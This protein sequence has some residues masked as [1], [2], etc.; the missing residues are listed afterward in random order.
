VELNPWWLLVGI[1]LYEVAQAVRTRGW[2]NILRASYPDSD[3]L[4]ARDVTAAYLAGAG[5]NG[6]VP[7]RGGDFLKVFLVHRRIPKARYSTL[8][9]TFGPETI[10]EIVMSMGLVI[11]AL[12]HGFLPV[13]VSTSDL[14][15]FDVSF[16]MTHP[17]LTVG[18]VTGAAA[19]LFVLARWCRPR[20]RCR[21]LY[22]RVKQGF[23]I[24]HSPRR[25]IVG[26]G[27]PQF[28]SRVVRLAA[29]VCL[30]KAVGLPVTVN[31]AILVMAAMSAG[32]I[33]PFA[34]ASTGLRVAML[35]YGFPALTDKPID[36]ASITSFWFTAGAVHLVGG[37]LISIGVLAYTFGTVSPRKA[38]S[39]IKAARV[40][41]AAAADRPLSASA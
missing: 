11:W 36:I 13:P 35:A 8:F 5:I 23:E 38:L 28:A 25:F 33:I 18:A 12:T 17:W 1:V 7:A 4:R 32:R 24:M 40:Q 29:M 16:V 3:D 14:P 9:A 6:I 37:L 39:A 15:E 31:T 41:T 19:I 20:S 26:V 2:F 34:P 21:G 27:G 30:M 22:A 10:P